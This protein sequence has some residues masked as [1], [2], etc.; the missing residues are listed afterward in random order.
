MGW[1][2]LKIILTACALYM[3]QVI[4]WASNDLASNALEKAYVVSSLVCCVGTLVLAW[5]V[6]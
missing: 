5:S 3:G 2:G 6:I 1:M 4:L